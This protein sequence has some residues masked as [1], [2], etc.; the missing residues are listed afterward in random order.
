MTA[1]SVEA[2]VARPQPRGEVGAGSS[3]VS[4]LE[5]NPASIPESIGEKLPAWHPAAIYGAGL[6]SCYLALAAMTTAMG[7]AFTKWIVPIDGLESFDARP[8]QWMADHRTHFL[9]SLSLV[10]SEISGGLVIPALVGAVVIV[11]ALRRRWLLAGFVLAAILIESA[12]YRTTVFF[13]DRDRPPVERL[14]ALP[15]DASFP[16]GHVAASIAVYSGFALLLTARMTST[17]AKALVWGAALAI[18]PIVAVSRMYRG[19][20]HPLDMLAGALMG[21]AALTLALLLARTTRVVARKR[22]ARA[23]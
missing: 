3:A 12:T 10:G 19:M 18:P 7:L 15:V 9:D 6:L 14:E 13:V 5:A 2:R 21:I 20:H 22:E 1:S 8:A 4:A 17:R 16:S 11:S 23:A